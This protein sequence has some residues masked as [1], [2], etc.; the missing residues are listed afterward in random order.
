[1]KKKTRK[2]SAPKENVELIQGRSEG[3]SNN[4]DFVRHFVYRGINGKLTIYLVFWIYCLFII[5]K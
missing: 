3:Q 1:M 4:N 5:L 2:S